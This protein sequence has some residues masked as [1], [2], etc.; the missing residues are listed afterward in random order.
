LTNN[1]KK[2]IIIAIGGL[3][4]YSIAKKPSVNEENNKKSC[5]ISLFNV[6][7]DDVRG[8]KLDIAF[9]DDVNPKLCFTCEA[10]DSNYKEMHD[11]DSLFCIDRE[12]NKYLY[13]I[14]DYLYHKLPPLVHNH[15][16][17]IN[18]GNGNIEECNRLILHRCGD[19]AFSLQFR[20]DKKPSNAVWVSNDNFDRN[21]LSD[22]DIRLF[23]ANLELLAREDY[24]NQLKLFHDTIMCRES[25]KVHK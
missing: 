15:V 20:S 12:Q 11:A 10:Y 16:R 22:D 14:F 18:S 23:I 13:N 8:E 19:M 5:V 3:G 4:M 9:F 25:T 6:E 17:V 2:I 7:S 21:N 24:K 1:V